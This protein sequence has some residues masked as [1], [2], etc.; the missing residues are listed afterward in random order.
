MKGII[1]ALSLALG[2][3]TVAF[4]KAKKAAAKDC[5]PYIVGYEGE[6]GY[7]KYVYPC[8]EH[9]TVT[10]RTCLEGEVGYFPTSDSRWGGEGSGP[11]ER[12]VCKN[13][14]FF[15]GYTGKVKHRKCNEGEVGYTHE[16]SS[17]FG[18]EGME[19]RIVCKH[20]R[21]VRM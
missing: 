18:G 3:S 16:S 7:A 1:F 4:A 5:N 19:V 6:G 14:T 15:P 20:G 2:C 9:Y 17:M 13:G 10:Y 11:E 12:R 21:F 8:G